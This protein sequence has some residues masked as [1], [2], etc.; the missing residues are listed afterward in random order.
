MERELRGELVGPIKVLAEVRE[1]EEL[2]DA[3]KVGAG[4]PGEEEEYT[5]EVNA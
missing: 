1:R 5:G 4:V 3:R 2:C